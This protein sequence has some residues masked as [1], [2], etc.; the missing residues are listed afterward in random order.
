MSEL[1]VT[2]SGEARAAI[3]A[4]YYVSLVRL[5]VQF[6]DDLET[7][8]DVVQDV[9]AAWPTSSEPPEPLRYLRSAV[10]NRARSVLRRR[11]TARLAS[12]RLFDR[13]RQDSTDDK[14]IVNETHRELL[15]HIARLP[16]RQREAVILRYYEG[17]STAETAAVL[18]IRA[19]AVTTS[20][21]KALAALAAH[22]E[23]HGH[24]D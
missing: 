18:G 3:Y 14:I 8:E 7:A 23:R 19:T 13:D 9:F 1:A 6:V 24:D 4:S 17:L 12:V 10:V 21:S 22:M 5:A 16:Q 15:A 20:L 11:R 2:P